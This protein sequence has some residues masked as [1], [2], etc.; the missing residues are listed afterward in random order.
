MINPDKIIKPIDKKKSPRKP[1]VV[2]RGAMA[3][4]L[5]GTLAA[6]VGACGG[7]NDNQLP[8]NGNQPV[9]GAPAGRSVAQ[10]AYAG[11]DETPGTGN[12]ESGNANPDV[13]NGHT[14]E[15]YDLAKLRAK[16][17]ADAMLREGEAIEITGTEIFPEDAP[18]GFVIT[19]VRADNG[20]KFAVVRETAFY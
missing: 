8:D 13:L 4:G 19:V 18:D 12:D 3:L 9:A 1:G 6:S 15:E 16:E 14:Q 10:G 11:L 2:L 7:D 20:K 17:L 5:A